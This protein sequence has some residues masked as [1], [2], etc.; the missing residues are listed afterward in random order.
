MYVYMHK[1][2]RLEGSGGML[3]QR[4][5]FEIRCS[6]VASEAILD[7]S[8]AILATWLV[9]HCIQFLAV[10]VCICYPTPAYGPESGDSYHMIHRKQQISTMAYSHIHQQLQ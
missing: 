4:F 3:P 2:D 8:R 9:E 6:E 10:H 7:R 1:H 5:V